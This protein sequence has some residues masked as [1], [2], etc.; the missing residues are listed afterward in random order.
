MSED[1]FGRA[2]EFQRET[3]KRIADEVIP[4]A[5]GCL[6]RTPSIPVIWSVNQIWFGE[7]V[8]FDDAVG[9]AERHLA[10]LPFRH[11]TVEDQ[12]TGP[13][14]EARF[15]AAG[16]NV[17]CEVTMV[18]G[19]PAD[20]EVDTGAVSEA[21]P[22]E[23]L[24]LMLRWRQ[25][26][27]PRE[28]SPDAERQ[29]TELWDREWNARNARLLGVRGRSGALAAITALYSDGVIAQVE[30]VYTV[31]E[32]RGRGFARML[33]TRAVQLAAEGR[34]E[35]TFIV[36]DDRDWPQQLYSRL[37]FDAVGRFWGFHR[38]ATPGRD[39]P[40]AR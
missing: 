15:A 26:T 3:H 14:V 39:Q 21:P 11:L 30:D 18:L 1:R 6:L 2:L 4:L 36:A 12:E 16:W 5:E 8:D 24:E 20:R 32:E 34:H 25:E 38:S 17:D 31:P 35:L 7:A 28:E 9:L 29:L 22:E 10:D 13:R 40:P 37:G 19:G 33:V 23:V 27:P